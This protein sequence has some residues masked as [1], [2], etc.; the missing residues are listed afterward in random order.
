MA[1]AVTSA[2]AGASILT[3]VVDFDIQ[4]CLYGFCPSH[5]SS[6]NLQPSD[7]IGRLDGTTERANAALEQLGRLSVEPFVEVYGSQLGRR[8]PQCLDK[9]RQRI[10]GGNQE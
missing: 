4:W 8:F 6:L 10:T 2:P 7:Q 9:R 5:L 1:S 3:S